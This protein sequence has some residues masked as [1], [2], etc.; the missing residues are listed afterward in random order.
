MTDDR[1]PDWLDT[2]RNRVLQSRSADPEPSVNGALRP[3]AVLVLLVDSDDGPNIV[4]TERAAALANYPGILVFPGGSAETID[5]G[6]VATALRE[7]A[8]ETGLEPAHVH[9]IG[10]LPPLHL[11]ETGFVVNPVVG[12]CTRLQ[13]T[14]TLSPQE[15]A[16]VVQIPLR[17]FANPSDRVQRNQAT[18]SSVPRYSFEGNA[19]GDMTSL[20]ID[21]LLD[22]SK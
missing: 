15:V 11:P 8:E 19:V 6:P 22:H 10:S 16:V 12:W 7:A 13:P 20:V 2:I 5:D 21:A 18:G 17:E 9:I 1:E 14:N 4:L 3:A